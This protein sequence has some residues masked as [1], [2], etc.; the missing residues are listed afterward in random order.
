M[1]KLLTFILLTLA[2]TVSGTLLLKI[3]VSRP[4]IGVIWPFSILSWISIGGIAIFGFGLLG[5]LT[6]LESLALNVAQPIFIGGQFVGVVLA[7]V[8]LLGEPIGVARLVGIALVF[9]GILVVTWS[10]S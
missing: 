6:V 8:L 2:C 1:L 9:T 4:G 7:S 3:G 5:Y 10:N